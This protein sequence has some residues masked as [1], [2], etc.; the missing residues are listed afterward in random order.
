MTDSPLRGMSEPG[1]GTGVETGDL[2]VME[3]RK[4]LRQIL[5]RKLGRGMDDPKNADSLELPLEAESEGKKDLSW[6]ALLNP[7][8]NQSLREDTE[9]LSAKDAQGKAKSS[10][11]PAKVPPKGKSEGKRDLNRKP[12]SGSVRDTRTT[13][14][15]EE[16]TQG[17]ISAR[18]ARKAEESDKNSKQS[19]ILQLAKRDLERRA[20]QIKTPESMSGKQGR[21]FTETSEES[22]GLVEVLVPP[23]SV[24]LPEVPKLPLEVLKNEPILVTHYEE[25]KQ[26]PSPRSVSPEKPPQ[27]STASP[28]V[29]GYR[30]KLNRPP[31]SPKPQEVPGTVEQSNTA[32]QTEEQFNLRLKRV[33]ETLSDEKVL[34][35]LRFVGG[36]SRY[37]RS[38]GYQD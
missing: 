34:K 27:T 3:G 19:L 24:C 31:L 10:T 38:C 30:P 11:K 2:G 37:L 15:V 36:L 33:L 25:V 18:S 32:V 20:N 13:T 26:S 21:T 29:P 4:Q 17:A 35:G 1:T 22:V 14:R 5:D 12:S 7:V 23:A 16:D 28:P 6:S 9:D 8:G